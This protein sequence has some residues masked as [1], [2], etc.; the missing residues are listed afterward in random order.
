M[1]NIQLAVKFMTGEIETTECRELDLIERDW[2]EVLMHS[3][4]GSVRSLRWAG[5]LYNCFRMYFYTST[6]Y[7][8]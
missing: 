7:C 6:V 8:N 1:K 3:T 5:Y 4:S 2:P